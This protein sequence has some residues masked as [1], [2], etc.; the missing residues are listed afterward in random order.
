[1]KLS[2]L[3]IFHLGLL[4][5][6]YISKNPNIK[7]LLKKLSELKHHADSAYEFVNRAIIIEYESFH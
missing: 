5:T 7:H 3:N 2:M 1:M 4:G 6:S